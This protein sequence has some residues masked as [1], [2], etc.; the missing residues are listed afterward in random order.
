MFVLQKRYGYFKL[1]L[2]MDGESSCLWELV[3][4]D[5]PL[6]LQFDFEIDNARLLIMYVRCLVFCFINY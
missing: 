2:C 1:V 5:V 6:I 4:R 3:V